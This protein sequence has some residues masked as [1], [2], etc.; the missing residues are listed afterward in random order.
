MI[1]VTINNDVFVVDSTDKLTVE[2]SNDTIRY[3]TSNYIAGENLL[4]I[5]NGT[6]RVFTLVN[7]PVLNSETIIF[8]KMVLERG[9]DYTISG[10]TITIAPNIPAPTTGEMLTTNYI[11]Q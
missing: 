10:N 1:A 8:A 4:G 5:K 9:T 11:K 7:I 3:N 6:N 2:F